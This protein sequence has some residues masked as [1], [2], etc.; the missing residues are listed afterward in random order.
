MLHYLKLMLQIL[1][2]P[3]RGWEDVEAAGETSRHTLLRGLLPLVGLAALTVGFGAL[4]QLHPTFPALLIKA[5]VT[6]VRYAISYFIGVAVLTYALPRL[7]RDGL[8]SRERVELFCAYC[9]G[10]MALIGIL[11]NLLPMELTLLQFLP[12]Y[13][14][15]V[16][17][18]GR[19][20]VDVD[21]RGIFR[22]AACAIVGI[23]LPVF[24]IDRLL[25]PAT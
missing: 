11:E 13:V 5:V 22:F 20:F 14:V 7:T 18:Q 25:L 6:F 2:A 9:V 1:M 3:Q 12:I 4:Y 15:V 24:L 19:A 16:I 21:E 23:I 8:V 10:M 17:C